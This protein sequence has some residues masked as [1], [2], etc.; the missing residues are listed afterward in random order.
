ERTLPGLEAELIDVRDQLANAITSLREVAGKNSDKETVLRT[1]RDQLSQLIEDQEDFI[2]VITSYKINVRACGNWITQVI[3]QPLALDRI[4]I[5]SPDVEVEYENTSFWSKLVYEIKRLFYSFII[6]YNMIG[7]VTDEDSENVTL[8]L[9]IGTGRDQ[10]NVI[11]SLIDDTFTNE[12]DINVNVQLVDMGTLLKA[13]LAGEGPDVAI[14]V[15][16]TQ[17]A[18]GQVAAGMISSANDTP[19]N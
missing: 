6:D 2:K 18:T 7:N 1:M 15:G 17:V 3:Q 16:P 11:K 5:Y 14:Q 12:T 10:A 19:V 13:T 4:N 8:T 9:W